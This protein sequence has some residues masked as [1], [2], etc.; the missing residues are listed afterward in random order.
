MVRQENTQLSLK[1][2]NSN[3]NITFDQSRT[4]LAIGVKECQTYAQDRRVDD[5]QITLELISALQWDLV[6]KD[7]MHIDRYHNS[8]RVDAMKL[9]LQRSEYFH[10]MSFLP[11][12]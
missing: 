4:R 12:F 3:K 5:S 11:C 6:P 7:I 10:N 1:C 2:K 9:S 8:H